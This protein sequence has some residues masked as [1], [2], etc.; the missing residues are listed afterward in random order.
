MIRL[1]ISNLFMMPCQQDVIISL[2]DRLAWHD[3]R[4]AAA[5]AHRQY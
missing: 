5:G 4:L 3:E 1:F 2:T